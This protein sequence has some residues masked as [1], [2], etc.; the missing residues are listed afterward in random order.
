M[1]DAGDELSDVMVERY[2]QAWDIFWGV[3][4]ALAKGED[5]ARFEHRD[6]HTGN[7]CISKLN[8]ATQADYTTGPDPYWKFG[9]SGF[10]TTIIDYTL[11]R[12]AIEEVDI[13]LGVEE[14]RVICTDLSK[15]KALFE[16]K[17]TYQYDVYR[18]QV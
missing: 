11:S 15:D 14:T 9:L 13:T 7:I 5:N 6:L 4:L 16:S 12:V 1:E 10:R 3:T 18:M 8:T 2:T 17:G